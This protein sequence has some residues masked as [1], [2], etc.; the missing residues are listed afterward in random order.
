MEASVEALS[1]VVVTGQ[2]RQ[3][4]YKLDKRVIEAS[5]FLSAAGG[6]VVDILS[7]TP[8]IRV[9]AEGDVSFRGSSG[10]KVYIDGKPSSLS[11]TVA[12]EQIPASQVENIEV[13]TV[14]SAR[15]DADGTPDSA[16][17]SF[18]F[19]FVLSC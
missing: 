14:P 15:N 16:P 12:L 6:T 9:D 1:E 18:F 5:G 10:F 2:R 11:G 3:I 7:Q 13:I 19:H 4:V 8:S 17:D